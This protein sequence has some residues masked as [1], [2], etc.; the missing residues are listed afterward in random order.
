MILA[1]EVTDRVRA[2]H[3]LQD[4]EQRLR[5]AIEASAIGDWE[6]DL[7]SGALARSGKFD[8]IFGY[9]TSPA[10]WS[11]DQLL[12]HVIPE[13]RAAFDGGEASGRSAGRLAHHEWKG[14]VEA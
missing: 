3:A 5:L 1:F 10:G 2:L 14:R 7:D 6:M 13:E 4:S 12:E 9:Q 8:E 11:Y